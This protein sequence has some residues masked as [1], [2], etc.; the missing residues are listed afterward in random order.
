VKPIT[1]ERIAAAIA[2]IA[3]QVIHGL[4]P[5]ETS[6]EG[7]LGYYAGL[8]LLAASA[9]SVAGLLARREWGRKLL[10]VVG[11]LVSVGFLLY[12]VTPISSPVT[13]PYIGE[14]DIGFAQWAPVIAAIAI[15]AWAA[16]ASV[17][18]SE[19]RAKF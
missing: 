18:K 13:N 8:V 9:A 19:R 5:A 10:G 4:I 17:R 15:G 16:F 2:L 11:V 6:A 7:S 1:A 12:H 14:P 3:V